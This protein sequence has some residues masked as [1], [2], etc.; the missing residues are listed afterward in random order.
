MAAK[1]ITARFGVPRAE[2][3][4]AI[5]VRGHRPK[6]N[7]QE[8]IRAILKVFCGA[9]EKA[10]AAADG[11]EVV[12]VS[13]AG[14]TVSAAEEMLARAQLHAWRSEPRC[15]LWVHNGAPFEELAEDARTRLYLD[16]AAVVVSSCPD[17]R[18]VARLDIFGTTWEEAQGLFEEDF[19]VWRSEPK[20]CTSANHARTAA[21]RSCRYCANTKIVP[22]PIVALDLAGVF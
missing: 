4:G 11:L 17:I 14:L 12:K 7:L 1:V 21:R 15:V 5:W 19:T 9:V 8:E 10:G 6:A 20:P 2:D 16:L 22:P 3:G 13:L 18:N